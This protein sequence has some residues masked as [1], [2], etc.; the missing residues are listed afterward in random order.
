MPNAPE[1]EVR[2]ARPVAIEVDAGPS[3]TQRLDAERAEQ[4]FLTPRVVDQGAFERFSGDLRQLIQDAASAGRALVRTGSDTDRHLASMRDASGELRKQ[5]ETGAR[6]IPT[7]DQRL[8]RIETALAKATERAEL[9]A[10][11]AEQIDRI[12]QE[13]IHGATERA[14]AVGTRLGE[15]LAKAQELSHAITGRVDGA[16]ERVERTA[17]RIE[18]IEATLAE[19]LARAETLAETLGPSVDEAEQR[20]GVAL[21][22]AEVS[23]QSLAQ[24][25]ADLGPEVEAARA[26]VNDAQAAANDPVLAEAVKAGEG[27]KRTLLRAV[28]DAKTIIEQADLARE[29]LAEDVEGVTAHFGATKPEP[30]PAPLPTVESTPGPEAPCADTPTGEAQETPVR[31]RRTDRVA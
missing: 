27:A 8:T 2:A 18:T 9:E 7:I 1:P 29:R 5:I 13:K 30:S 23:S 22:E 15:A 31:F 10:R 26:L 14:A 17:T 4:I 19:R 28:R 3:D 20:I 16:V 6:L 12:V 24:V 21:T 25:L 11:I